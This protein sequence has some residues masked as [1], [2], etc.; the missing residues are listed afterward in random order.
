MKKKILILSN[1][2]IPII[3]FVI[4]LFNTMSSN[5]IYII[6]LS[7]FIGWIIPFIATIISGLSILN[8]NNQK[9]TLV[10]NI[11]ALLLNLL[12]ILLII[13]ILDNKLILILIEYIVLSIIT[14]INIIYYI[15][16]F[17]NNKD[18]EI[19][20]IKKIKSENNGIIK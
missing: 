16:Y 6:T 15:I 17:I 5:F 7:L 10:F 13:S 18:D 8:N 11:F 12:L 4:L 2:I 9:L 3:L 20:E 14:I 19:S 1:I